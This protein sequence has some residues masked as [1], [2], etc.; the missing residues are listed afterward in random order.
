VCVIAE[1]FQVFL[2]ETLRL[3]RLT[4]AVMLVCSQVESPDVAMASKSINGLTY[5]LFRRWLQAAMIYDLF[6]WPTTMSLPL[7]HRDI[8]GTARGAGCHPSIGGAE[9]FYASGLLD[10]LPIAQ[11]DTVDH[12]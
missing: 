11:V 7:I 6:C 1:A 3:R 8:W 10:I 5:V 2:V 9:A 4:D 12:S